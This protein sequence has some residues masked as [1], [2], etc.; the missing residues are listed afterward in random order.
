M[1]RPLEPVKIVKSGELDAEKTDQ[2]SHEEL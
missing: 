2:G 1:D